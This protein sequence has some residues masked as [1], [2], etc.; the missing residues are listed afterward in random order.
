[1]TPRYAKSS[2]TDRVSDYDDDDWPDDA[3]PSWDDPLWDRDSDGDDDDGDGDDSPD[4]PPG[5]VTVDAAQS[6]VGSRPPWQNGPSG[7][8]K[9]YTTSTSQV[10]ASGGCVPGVQLPTLGRRR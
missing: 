9:P 6:A 1:M 5:Y 4:N 8:P 10:D 3:E 7:T 2:G